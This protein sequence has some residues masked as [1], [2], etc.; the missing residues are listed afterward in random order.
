[1]NVARSLQEEYA[2][3]RTALLQD[4]LHPII[5]ELADFI[6]FPLPHRP[7]YKPLRPHEWHPN[8]ATGGYL[9]LTP[10]ERYEAQRKALP[11]NPAWEEEAWLEALD[12]WDYRCAVCRT[13]E[14]A[15]PLV[16]DHLIPVSHAVCPGTIPS[17]LLPLCIEC[18][19]EKSN[20]DLAEWAMT[21][22]HDTLAL[23]RKIW[24]WQT[25]IVPDHPCWS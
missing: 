11:Y 8:Y 10:A 24:R 15:I 23:V 22:R 25:E 18:N 21:G 1:M 13:H 20:K 7:L 5:I 19:R 16:R 2:E 4:R 17:N 9:V 12:F 3:Q 6:G 14:D